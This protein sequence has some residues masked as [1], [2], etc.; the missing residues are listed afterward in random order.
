M[1]ATLMK[2]LGV[3]S[4]TALLLMLGATVPAYAQDEHNQDAKPEKQ[5]QAKPAKQQEAAK[6]AKQEEQAKPER[7]QEQA[8]TEKQ[9]PEAKPAKQEEKAKPAQEEKQ[10]KSEKQARPAKQE[11]QAN[12]EKQPKSEKQPR[13][14][15]QAKQENR[16]AA[17]GQQH[18]QRT[19]AE[20]QRQRSVPALRLSVRSESR[21]PDDRFH[22]NFGREHSFRIGTPTMVGGYS[23]FQY[24]GYWFGFVQPWPDGWYY[25]DDVYVDY[26]D[27]GYYLCNP[28]YPGA[29]VAISVQL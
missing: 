7:Q 18:A 25:T 16:G 4:T 12:A 13:Q 11:E 15:E 5:E 28:Y 6:P 22:S 2:A 10:A 23:R 20:Q 14:N 26:I 1:E 29:Q 24:G 17:G 9:A 19:E 3:I 8:K 21:I 27:G